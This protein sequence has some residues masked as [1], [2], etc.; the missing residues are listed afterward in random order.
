MAAISSIRSMTLDLP[1]SC[2]EFCPE[3][4]DYF[5]V[6]TYKLWK[7]EEEGG[8][9]TSTEASDAE[10]RKEQRRT[11][12]LVTFTIKGDEITQVHTLVTQFAV[13]DLHFSPHAAKRKNL[14]CVATSTGALVLYRLAVNQHASQD[15]L[16]A[17]LQHVA[18][19]SLFPP[20]TLVFSC[21]WHPL[22]P[23]LVGVTLSTGEVLLYKIEDGATAAPD[24]VCGGTAE[25]NARIDLLSHS[26]EA[27]TLA[28]TPRGE[29]VF[30]GGDDA[31]LQARSL[32]GTSM[33][34]AVTPD[35][36]D[37]R[38]HG[39]GITAILPLPGEITITGNYDDHIRVIRTPRV[40]RR[41]ILAEQNLGGGVWRLKVLD[42][43]AIRD[44]HRTGARQR[45]I[46]LASCMHAGA[47]IL[48]ITRCTDETWSI[49][50]LA[51]FEEHKSMNYGSDVQPAA[52]SCKTPAIIS[53][54]FYDQLLCMWRWSPTQ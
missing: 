44:A 42:E 18:T 27:W 33:Q 36:Q 38:I 24:G 19:L 53:T 52:E 51:K 21:A 40:G 10:S 30:S 15:I 49:D 2:I 34:D 41:E 29:V 43:G 11:G 4:P 7:Q 46:L 16:A 31:I 32:L 23:S 22:E 35:W 39:A 5:V 45:I 14:L 17:E 20:T 9:S 50:V 3:N 54:S 13:L 48:S 25:L 6:G 1:P 47:R 28:F 12:S 8:E 26:L 37:R